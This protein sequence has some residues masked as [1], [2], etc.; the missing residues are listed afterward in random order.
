M[1]KMRK[2][3]GVALVA[4]MVLTMNLSVF[5]AGSKEVTGT[6]TKATAVDK[7]GKAVDVTLANVAESVK[8]EVSKVETLKKVLG[9]KF[10]EGMK[11]VD[12]KDVEVKEG[13]TFPLTITFQVANVNANT[14]VAVLHSPDEGKSWETASVS[15]VKAGN[16]TITATFQSLSPVAFVVDENT[17]TPSAP[18]TGE[19]S[20]VTVAALVAVVAV[21]GVVTFRKKEFN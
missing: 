17:A 3:L 1:R 9:D 12:V 11:V 13:T 20:M 14:K 6:V 4:A 15:N 2:I 21:A 16:G 18:R 10:V 7:D 5:A 8:T 19:M